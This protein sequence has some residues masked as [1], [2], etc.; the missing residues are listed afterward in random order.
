MS[1]MDQPLC[2]LLVSKYPVAGRV[3]TRLASRIGSENAAALARCFLLDELQILA[4][5][6][7]PITLFYDPPESGPAFAALTG[8]RCVLRPQRGGDLGERMGHVFEE[9]FSKGFPAALLVGS[10]LPDLPL[11]HLKEAA[12]A[13]AQGKAVLGPAADGGYYLIGFPKDRYLPQVFEDIPWSTPRVFRRTVERFD[14]S[15]REVHLLPTWW[16]MDTVEDLD[17]FQRRGNAQSLTLD[18]LR[19]ISRKTMG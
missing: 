1:D 5:M 15:G 2:L 19:E 4:R 7:L 18:C 6:N 9:S 17:A 11:A 8:N 12:A 16:D 13:L 10:D 3:K 14:A